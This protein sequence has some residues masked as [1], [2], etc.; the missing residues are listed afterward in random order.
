MSVL[1]LRAKLQLCVK[2]QSDLGSPS[3]PGIRK[4]QNLFP[5]GDFPSRLRLPLPGPLKP[6]GLVRDLPT[7]LLGAAVQGVSVH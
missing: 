4:G 6:V 7:M 3:E 2:K 1:G 5:S